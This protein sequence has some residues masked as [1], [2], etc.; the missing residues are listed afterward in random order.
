MKREKPELK[1]V[2]TQYNIFVG[3]YGKDCYGEEDV[4]IFEGNEFEGKKDIKVKIFEDRWR[5]PE[6]TIKFLRDLADALQ[7]HFINPQ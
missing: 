6:I 4:S 3:N 2:E 1:I 7:E 5:T